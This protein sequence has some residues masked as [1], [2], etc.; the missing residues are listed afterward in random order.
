MNYELFVD[1]DSGDSPKVRIWDVC[2]IVRLLQVRKFGQDGLI[3]I[4]R[5]TLAAVSTE[6]QLLR[7]RRRSKS[8]TACHRTRNR[9]RGPGRRCRSPGSGEPGA[10]R[11]G[12][13]AGRPS[14]R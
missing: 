4:P 12:E 7:A 13:A 6:C 1:V 5:I 10:Y 9:P 11:E 3:A 8:G 14:A 2:C